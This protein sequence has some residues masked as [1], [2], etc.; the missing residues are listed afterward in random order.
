MRQMLYAAAAI[1]LT[2]GAAQAE[3]VTVFGPWLGPDQ[4][5]VESGLATMFAMSA[6]TDSSSRSWW[7]PKPDR[8]RT[9]P[10][11]R[12][13]AWQQP[14]PHRIA[15][16]VG[17]GEDFRGPSTLRLAN[18]LILSPLLHHARNGEPERW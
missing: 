18:C 1:A 15:E 17:Q 14:E 3:Q 13:R 16:R 8:P 6:P 9:S 7:M 12:S 10:C 5:A 2:A 4:E 11:S